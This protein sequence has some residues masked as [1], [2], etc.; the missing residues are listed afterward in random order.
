QAIENGL[1]VA[2]KPA[3]YQHIGCIHGHFL[4]LKYL[5]LADARP[6]VFIT[7]MRDPIERLVSHY[8]YWYAVYDPDSTDTRPLHRRVVEEQWSLEQFC[9]SDAMRNLYSQLL[10]G[11]PLERFDFIGITEHYAD[12]LSAFSQAFLGREL[13]ARV[14]NPRQSPRPE[15]DE[16]GGL[17]RARVAKWHAA[18][19]ELYRRALASRAARHLDASS[20]GR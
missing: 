20:V 4:P 2:D 5:L 3:D 7:W 8:H 11:F 17:L 15:A 9:L 12:D 10:W 16:L 18:D 14:R 13:P 6:T 19:C 1:K